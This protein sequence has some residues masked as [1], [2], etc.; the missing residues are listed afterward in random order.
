MGSFEVRDNDGF[1][2]VFAREPIAEDSV[3]FCLKGALSTK[4]SRY[5]IQLGRNEHLD[6]PAVREANDD[7]DYCWQYLN[8][9]C[10]PNGYINAS[11][12]TFRALRDI[13]AGEQ[14]TINYLTT[15]SEMAVPFSCG[16]GSPNCFGWISGRKF[17]TPEQVERL[18]LS[19]SV[20][21]S[22]SSFSYPQS[23]STMYLTSDND[24]IP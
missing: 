19:P 3:I 16:C 22:S 24:L 18:S 23:N 15:E 1:K 17:L 20:R 8:H 13:V 14:I 6:F 5:S 7:L 21:I 4:P 10:G 12:L 9:S 2:G 11:D